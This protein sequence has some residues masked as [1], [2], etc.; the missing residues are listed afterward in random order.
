MACYHFQQM[1]TV[2]EPQAQQGTLRRQSRSFLRNLLL[3]VPFLALLYIQLVHHVLWRDELNAFAI[4][5][6][7]PTVSS[8]FHHIHYE[9]HPWLWYA[10]LWVLS[11]FTESIASMKLLQAFIGSAIILLIALRSP[12]RTWEKALILSGYFIVFEY[13]VLIRMYGVLLLLLVL[14][15]W[16]RVERPEAPVIGAV[17]LGLMA[18]TDSLGIILSFAL[19]LEYALARRLHRVAAPPPRQTALAA[20]AYAVLTGFAIWSAR[21]TPDISWRTTGRPF[22]HAKS[23]SHLYN[24]LLKYTVLPFFPAQSPRSGFFW[25]PELH[26]SNLAYTPQL[27]LIVAILYFSFRRYPNLLLLL[28]ATIAAGTLLSHLIYPGSERHFGV[29]FLAFLAALWI[30][31][32]VAPGQ[33]APY[34]VYFLLAIS[35][36]SSV[37]A[38]IGSFHRPFSNDK[39]AA[40][41][42]VSNNLEQ[43]PLVGEED[44]SVVGVAEYMHRPIYMI[45]CA[46]V[47]RFLL[48][49][50]R[51]DHYTN[52]DAP[53]RI[54]GAE[55]FYH[56]QPLLFVIVHPMHPDEQAALE[57]EGFRI[58]PLAQFSGA[59][60]IAENFYFYRLEL[61][62]AAGAVSGQPRSYANTSKGAP[63]A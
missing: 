34:A 16:R 36:L 35:A 48:F 8:L 17:L 56:D 29:V 9:G 18:S 15:L 57:H 40:Q 60:E 55:H 44:T 7:S 46:C 21:P 26:R 1:L 23:L 31:R 61:A 24:A 22:A 38:V 37:W 13:T 25:N 14:Y 62:P 12:F 51:R 41:W 4:T 6:A 27:L 2:R 63:Y 47:D 33:R 32:G 5:W 42:I 3:A 30:A 11:R 53:Q 50:S 58:Q 10:I 43:M 20:A 49:G 28:G 59:E 45:E 39:A 19:V 54:L 52:A